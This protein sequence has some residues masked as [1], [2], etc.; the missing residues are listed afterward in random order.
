MRDLKLVY[1]LTNKEIAEDELIKL[2]ENEALNITCNPKLAK[3]LGTFIP[4]L[5]IYGA[6]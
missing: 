2:E 5:Q 4:I 6:N 1:R 3:Q